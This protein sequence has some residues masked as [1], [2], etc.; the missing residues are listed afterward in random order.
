MIRA[1]VITRS[2]T[3]AC[4]SA[5]TGGGK[6]IAAECALS[7]A[8]ATGVRLALVGRSRPET[9][10]ELAANLDRMASKGVVARYFMADVTSAEA[11]Q[12]AVRGVCRLTD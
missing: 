9:D 5:A 11:V 8:M 6:G 10:P 1:G 4:T 2:A 7:L 3:R 12:Q